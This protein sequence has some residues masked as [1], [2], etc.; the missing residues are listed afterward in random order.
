MLPFKAAKYELTCLAYLEE[1]SQLRG[2]VRHMHWSISS[3]FGT[4]VPQ[5]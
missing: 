5:C 3:D 2:V 4:N 1:M